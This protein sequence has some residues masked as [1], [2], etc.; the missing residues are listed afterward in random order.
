ML[1][2]QKARSKPA[3]CIVRH[4]YYPDSHV[5]RD[6]EALVK[7]GY[8]VSVIALRREGQQPLE[9]LNGVDIH[10]LPVEHRRGSALRY[11][12]EYSSFALLAF[13]RLTL[14]HIR[15]RFQ[16]VEIDNMPDIL[17]FSAIV[18]RL[19]GT[20]VILYIFDNM[21][22]LLAYLWGTTDRHPVVRMLAFLERI[23]AAFA[24]RVIV[25][26]EMPRRIAVARGVPEEKLTVV[27]NCAD[28]TIFNC[29]AVT[30]ASRDGS[31]FEIV[32]HGVI[33]ER[34][35][36]QVLV[37]ALPEVLMSVPDTHVQ[38]FGAGEYRDELERRVATLGLEQHV[39]F[40]GFA[41]LDELLAGIAGADVGYV[42]MLN[43]QVLPNK[44]MEYVAMGVPVMLSRWPT[45]TYYFPED[46]ATYF[47]AGDATDL[48]RA[49][50]R[51]HQDREAALERATRGRS[52]YQHYRWEVQRE[53]YLALYAE[54][55]G[56]GRNP[57][58][59]VECL[60]PPARYVSQDD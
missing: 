50:I 1:R 40:R 22:E 46:S 8:D 47:E 33:L 14:L 53:V 13:L 2:R 11:A 21:P 57:R 12:W 6:A 16:V 49:L 37:D 58:V 51:V 34:Y 42:G 41:P 10:R 5:R 29:D 36:I 38:I 25:T 55:A 44:L 56:F 27:L 54:L 7:A 26:Q 45:F 9:T 59:A 52:R 19:T 31:R 17:V 28:E 20:P 3:V 48:A 18:P 39:H 32:T 60:V 23:S 24:N 43:D 35:G 30:R 4:N 15:K